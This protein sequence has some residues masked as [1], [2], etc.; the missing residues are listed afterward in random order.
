MISTFPFSPTY[1]YIFLRPSYDFYPQKRYTK[2]AAHCDDA[3][4]S[5]SVGAWED[6]QDGS[7]IGIDDE[8]IHPGYTDDRFKNDIMIHHLKRASS[9]QYIQLQK[10][11]IDKAGEP[12]TVVGFGTT[13]AS[14]SQI[15]DQLQEVVVNFVDRDECNE[16]YGMVTS[17]MLCAAKPGADSCSGD[18]GGPLFMK[19]NSVDED[20][21]VGLVSWG[22]GCA[23]VSD[24]PRKSFFFVRTFFLKK[25]YWPN[26]FMGDHQCLFIRHYQIGGVPG[27][28]H[29]HSPLF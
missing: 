15:P 13:D 23:E 2:G 16:V 26:N 14:R 20:R 8:V 5:F 29:K 24:Y 11:P 9:N 25:N 18:S 4:D 6:V 3:A 28:I 21:L 22:R 12:L 17:D 27:C 1:L 19:G 10:S 7:V